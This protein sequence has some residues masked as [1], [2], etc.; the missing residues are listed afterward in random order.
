MY[1]SWY[2]CLENKALIRTSTDI[3]FIPQT[4][5]VDMASL[6]NLRTTVF[7]ERGS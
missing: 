1:H 6:Y 7:R 3:L 2:D 4:P 5:T